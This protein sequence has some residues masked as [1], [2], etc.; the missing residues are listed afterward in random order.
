MIPVTTNYDRTAAKRGY[1]DVKDGKI[2]VKL[3]EPIH[4][5]EIFDVFGNIGFL[6]TSYEMRDDGIYYKEFEI[7]EFSYCFKPVEPPNT[8]E[9]VGSPP[10]W[11]SHLRGVFGTVFVVL[12]IWLAFVA[13]GVHCGN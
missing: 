6:A 7:C 10:G 13:G 3:I 1:V 8:V 9:Y 5:K 4:E 11:Y 2:L 12:S